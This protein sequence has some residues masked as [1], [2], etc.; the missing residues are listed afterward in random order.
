MSLTIDIASFFRRL[1]KAK[2]DFPEISDKAYH[3]IVMKTGD[4]PKL[5]SIV[6]LREKQITHLQLIV[7][8]A[9]FPVFML[10]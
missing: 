7:L 8:L 4:L 9:T 3:E 5:H 2:C 6:S 10:A 1:Q